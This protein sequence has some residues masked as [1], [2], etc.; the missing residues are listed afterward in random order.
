MI[1]VATNVIVRLLTGD[2]QE[3]FE[4]SKALF[5]RESVLVTSTVVFECEWGLR[6]AYHFKQP[7]ITKTF[8]SLFGLPNVELE[9]PLVISNAIEWHQ[10]GMDFA[11]ALHL[12]QSKDAEAF[13]TFNKKLIK[14]AKKILPSR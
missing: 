12:A 10:N 14:V 7:E 9:D 4:K 11:D 2:D 5:S 3:Q 1:S 6:Y 13:A 8:Q